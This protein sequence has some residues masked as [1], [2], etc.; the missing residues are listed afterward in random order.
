MSDEHLDAGELTSLVNSIETRIKYIIQSSEILLNHEGQLQVVAALY[1]HAIEE[2]GKL[3]YVLSIPDN[4][5]ITTV[6][7]SREWFRN[8]DVKI[9]LAQ[10]IL[11]PEC[12]VLQQGNYGSAVYGRVDY[13]VHEVPDW[14]TR[15]AILNTDL[16]DGRVPP[17][18]A[19][20]AGDITEAIKQFKSF[21]NFD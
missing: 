4:M 15:L 17:L 3:V 11:P 9:E 19:V 16:E 10:A 14:E 6:N 13:D 8:H 7:T 1:I 20:D 2:F 5:G 21:M 18:P 12:F